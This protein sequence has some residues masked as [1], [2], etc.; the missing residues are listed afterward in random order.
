MQFDHAADVIEGRIYYNG[1]NNGADKAQH[2]VYENHSGFLVFTYDNYEQ[3]K[4][5]LQTA[6]SM[7]Q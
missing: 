7:A 5:Q 6:E 3:M 4:E 2:M 1:K